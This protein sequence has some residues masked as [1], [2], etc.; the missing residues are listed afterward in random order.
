MPNTWKL[1][2][3]FNA[4]ILP[5]AIK[6]LNQCLIFSYGANSKVLEYGDYE[7]DRNAESKSNMSVC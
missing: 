3:L 7:R 4:G 1:S 5:Q 6:T 2:E